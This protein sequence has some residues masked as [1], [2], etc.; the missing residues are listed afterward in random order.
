MIALAAELSVRRMVH[1]I[2]PRHIAEL[3]WVHPFDCA[4]IDAEFQRIRASLVVCV[5]PAGPTEV[6][7]GHASAEGVELQ[8]LAF[9]HFHSAQS[10]RNHDGAA[11]SAI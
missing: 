3:R 10:R 4:H 2:V 1:P 8:T 5:N 11:P 6:V 7:F 9:D